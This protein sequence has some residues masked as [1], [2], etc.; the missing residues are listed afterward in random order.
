MKRVA[1]VGATGSI[2]RQTVDAALRHPE[3]FRITGLASRSDRAGLLALAGMIRDAG[4]ASPRLCLS[5]AQASDSELEFSGVDGLERFVGSVDADILLN[6][7]SGAAGLSV[8]VSALK[9]GKDLALANKETIVMA[10][11]LVLEL[12]S[13]L[14]RRVVPV[15]S[16]HWAI[17]K[18]I[19]GVGRANV[20]SVTITA[21]GGAFRD[22][23]IER[24]D[25]VTPS[26]ALAHPTWNMGP[27]ITIDSASM[28]NKGLEVIE[29]A[30]LFELPPDRIE[31]AIHP[32][33]LVHSFVRTVDG[34]LYA[35]ISKPDMRLP[36]LGA[37]AWPD[38]V[39]E[40][41]PE[42]DPTVDSMTFRKP[43]SARY[44]LLG[45]AYDA[46]KSGEGAT[47]AYNAANEAA[48]EAFVAGSIRFVDI[49]YVVGE[50]LA[51]EYPARL[52]GLDTVAESDA[53]ARRA[54]GAAIERKR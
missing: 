2:G 46:L 9:G 31:V 50:A 16:E 30:R 41:F 13:K 21:S 10:G 44:P 28:A 23:S 22:L 48:V 25:R 33:S 18:L 7:A 54:A 5:G 38:T 3:L 52:D 27:K 47:A 32:E 39:P 6:A 42:M 12:A 15:D 1:V 37:L 36:I 29:A 51:S 24:L 14:G 35:Q 40:S 20:R 11:R 49:A 17:F 26:D 4:F 43:E 8:S 53:L 45:L 19:A 34:A